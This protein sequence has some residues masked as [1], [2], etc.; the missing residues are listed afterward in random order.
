[1]VDC[2]CVLSTTLP[3]S[4]ANLPFSLYTWACPGREE[5]AGNLTGDRSFVH[6]FR[7]AF[8]MGLVYNC[9][10]LALTLGSGMVLALCA[11]NSF[12]GFAPTTRRL[13][14]PPLR[15]PGMSPR[16][17]ENEIGH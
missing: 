15:L 14:P 9:S 1:M 2:H 4:D 16:M 6:R 7:K 12:F 3:E 11:S 5:E 13:E 10:C 8:A 17:R